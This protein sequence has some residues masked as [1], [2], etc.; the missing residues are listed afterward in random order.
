M[1]TPQK[2]LPAPNAVYAPQIVLGTAIVNGQITGVV[3]QCTLRAAAVDAQG[4]WT[5]AGIS[6]NLGMFS[7]GFD[8]QGNV[9]GLPADLAGLAADFVAACA[10]LTALIGEVNAIRKVL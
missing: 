1:I 8:A 3:R 5:D 9:T 7:F 4:N 6:G 10:A 2:S